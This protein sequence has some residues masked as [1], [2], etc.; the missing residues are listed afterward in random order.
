MTSQPAHPLRVDLDALYANR[1]KP[2]ELFT[3]SV[4][5]DF[6]CIS[7]PVA[8]FDTWSEASTYAMQHDLFMGEPKRRLA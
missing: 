5:R 4:H 1:P 6:D 2:P 3:G 7:K 8:V